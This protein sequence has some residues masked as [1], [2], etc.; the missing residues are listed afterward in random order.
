MAGRTCSVCTSQHRTAIERAVIVGVSYRA[1][2]SEYG[3]SES[4]ISRH[5]LNH[6]QPD[7]VSI[8]MD[9]AEDAPSDLLARV[10][11]I[12]DD[13]R[14]LRVNAQLSGNPVSSV[15]AMDAELKAIAFAADKLGVGS[16][17][18]LK[19]YENL[20]S[21]VM[22]VRKL[23]ERHPKVGIELRSLIRP[24][25]EFALEFVDQN[26]PADQSKEVRKS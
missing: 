5:W 21:V 20:G 17:T 3:V 19:N 12:A 13:A 15:R 1:I 4:S 6:R 23:I 14:N 24:D 18:L 16:S 9:Y 8:P 2:A 10:M 11:S 26:L 7:L 22:A 25:Q